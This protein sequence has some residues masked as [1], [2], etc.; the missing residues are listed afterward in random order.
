MKVSDLCKFVSDFSKKP[1][2][3]P[4]FTDAK[5]MLINSRECA[6]KI[7]VNLQWDWKD[8]DLPDSKKAIISL[9]HTYNSPITLAIDN[10]SL[11]PYSKDKLHSLNEEEWKQVY[12]ESY[13]AGYLRK[14]I[15]S[16]Q[17]KEFIEYLI[18]N[19][20]EKI[21]SISGYIAISDLIYKGDMHNAYIQ[22]SEICQ[23]HWY[24]IKRF[25]RGKAYCWTTKQMKS[26]I[27]NMKKNR[28]RRI[29]VEAKDQNEPYQELPFWLQGVAWYMAYADVCCQ[30]DMQKAHRQMSA[31]CEIL[32]KKMEHLKW[33]NRYMGNTKAMKQSMQGVQKHWNNRVWVSTLYQDGVYTTLPIW[34][35]GIS[36]YIAYADV[37]CKWHM[38]K[39]YNQMLALCKASNKNIH[40]LGRG[41]IYA[42]DTKSIRKEIN[43]YKSLS[44]VSIWTLI[45]SKKLHKEL[46]IYLLSLQWYIVWVSE[47][48]WLWRYC[49]LRAKN[50]KDRISPWQYDL[51]AV[52]E[53][54]TAK[55]RLDNEDVSEIRLVV[56]EAIGKTSTWQ[57]QYPIDW[58]IQWSISLYRKR[59]KW[60]SLHETLYWII[61]TSP[62]SKIS[63]EN[64]TPITIV[65]P[66]VFIEDVILLCTKKLQSEYVDKLKYFLE[67]NSSID[68]IQ[69]V[70]MKIK[71]NKELFIGLLKILLFLFC[72]YQSINFEKQ[73]N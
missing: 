54:Y 9:F 60:N 13:I 72:E 47:L 62:K 25:H 2:F 43:I 56:N 53:I 27:K 63:Y 14:Y 34:L 50:N 5:K 19:H 59:K 31:I 37:Y 40:E 49:R 28:D 66:P 67:N 4:T 57:V 70:I 73:H 30:W 3:I 68:S 24:S 69:D 29:S 22:I 55:Y 38:H 52:A 6:K 42:W 35:H 61:K 8:F 20:W 45:D 26:S 18:L 71:E 44:I 10:R 15:V 58:V 1:F 12:I 51:A 32:S 17:K 7:T 23:Q 16:I 48:S 41:S 11:Q 46:W 21:Q 65:Q 36:W 33:W 64:E 39:A